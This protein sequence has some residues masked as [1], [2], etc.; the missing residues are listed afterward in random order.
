MSQYQNRFTFDV[1]RW[2]TLKWIINI[3]LLCFEFRVY[4]RTKVYNI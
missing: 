4:I 1:L 2:K 3:I